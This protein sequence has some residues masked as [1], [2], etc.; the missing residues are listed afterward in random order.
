MRPQKY[1]SIADLL[2]HEFAR[3][4]ATITIPSVRDLAARHRVAYP[5]MWK[6]VRVLHS[7]GVLA[8]TRGRR[9]ALRRGTAKG[10]DTASMNASER[11]ANEV[12]QSIFDGRYRFGEQ[13]P[14]LGYFA[15]ENRM[16]TNTAAQAFRSLAVD[17]LIHRRGRTWIVGA[18]ATNHA[19][20]PQWREHSVVFVL[21]DNIAA[22]DATS[23]SSNKI[24]FFTP[25]KDEFVK[26]GFTA[27]LATVGPSSSRTAAPGGIAQIHR[28]ARQLG[29]AYQ[30]TL[31]HCVHPHK[32]GLAA[33]LPRLCALGKPVVY[34][35]LSD[36][37]ESF[38]RA[39]P[40]V[41]KNFFR[42][43]V[44]EGAAIDLALD[45]LARAGHRRVGIHAGDM[46]AWARQRSARILQRAAEAYPDIEIVTRGRVEDAWGITNTSF[47][48]R[49][50]VARFMRLMSDDADDAGSMP[51]PEGFDAIKR[52]TASLGE[53]LRTERPTALIA[54][55][56]QLAGAY[57]HWLTFAGIEVPARLSLVS[58]DNSTES[59]LLP[60]STVEFGIPRLGYLAAHL[61]VG[62]LAVRADGRGWIASQCMLADRGSIA[63]ASQSH[64]VKV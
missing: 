47:K 30:G 53:F 57:Y 3:P 42:M 19:G 24:A 9:S 59:M 31:I 48:V 38:A 52:D 10:P 13:L 1:L 35:D 23:N 58:F 4:S 27:R 64:F 45:S 61:F 20:V 62:D 17:G 60:V 28:A 36:E 44:D 46:V 26:H 6:A 22:W 29:S 55:N 18:R 43:H 16:S 15:L 21:V 5:T 37:G 41:G 11:L 33:V 7:R 2:E 56:D 8:S 34:A 12:R 32:I 25:L 14:K 49:N 54:L 40:G 63:N 50:L 39:M 51:R